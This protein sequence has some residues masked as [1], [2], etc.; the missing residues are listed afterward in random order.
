M[1]RPRKRDTGAIRARYGPLTTPLPREQ[2][3]RRSRIRAGRSRLR[4]RRL[5]DAGVFQGVLD[6]RCV[7]PR[8]LMIPMERGLAGGVGVLDEERRGLPS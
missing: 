4:G 6:A 7:G 3:R 5:D 1:S 2:Y 8:E